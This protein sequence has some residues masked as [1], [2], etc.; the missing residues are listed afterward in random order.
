MKQVTIAQTEKV[1]ALGQG[2][3]YMGDNPAL[4]EDEVAAL[5][6]GVE[7]GMTVIDTAEMYGSGKSERVVGEAIAPIRDEVFLVSKV[8]PH[9]A[10]HEGTIEACE[11]SLNRLGTDRLDLYL[12]HW[13]GPYPLEETIEAFQALQKQGKIRHWGVSNFDPYDMSDLRNTEGGDRVAT[14]QVLYN[15]TRRGIE[16]DLLPQSEKDGL[17]I[18][19]YSPIEQARLLRDGHLQQLASDLG[20][21]AA[22]L[23]LAWVIRRK[24]VIAIPKSGDVHHVEANAK[25]SDI[26]LSED[27]LSALDS[28]FPAPKGPTAL[29]IL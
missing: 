3:W 5:R 10:S 13:P 8:L 9:N 28:L 17:P 29:E 7:L 11:A 18:M 20:V 16:W 25:A 19:A 26:E 1:P 22:Q 24:G 15:L 27:A 2:T 12:L 21:T 4:K 14:N 6:R 23:A